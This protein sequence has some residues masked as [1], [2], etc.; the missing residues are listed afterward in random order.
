MWYGCRH[1]HPEVSDKCE[2]HESPHAPT[3]GCGE[4]WPAVCTLN[5]CRGLTSA[6][7]TLALCWTKDLENFLPSKLSYKLVTFNYLFLMLR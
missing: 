2:V 1:G 5:T 3:L 7:V 4:V 6:V